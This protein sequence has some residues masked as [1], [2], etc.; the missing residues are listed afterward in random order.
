M[1][2]DV[3]AIRPNVSKKERALVNASEIRFRLADWLAGD[4]SLDEFDDWFVPATWDI[5]N[6]G[7]SEAEVLTDEIELR[8]SEYT[9][10]VLSPEDLKRE[11]SALA[12]SPHSVSK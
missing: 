9:D 1:G 11:L 7:D 5:H 10:G 4:R 12:G 3:S 8:L 6:S 2:T